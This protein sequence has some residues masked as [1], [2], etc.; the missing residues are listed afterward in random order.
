VELIT[1]AYKNDHLAL[2]ACATISRSFLPDGKTPD[3]A[4]LRRNG[5]GGFS[6]VESVQLSD[7]GTRNEQTS[8]FWRSLAD[9]LVSPLH[10]E[11]PDLDEAIA[12]RLSDIGLGAGFRESFLDEVLPDGAAVLMLAEDVCTREKALAIFRSFGGRERL[13]RLITAQNVT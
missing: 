1:A 5:S 11:S 6:L 2:L 7:A 3:Y 10:P 9:L 8:S 12:K 13:V 4:L